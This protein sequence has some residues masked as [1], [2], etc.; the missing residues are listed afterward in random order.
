GNDYMYG[1]IGNDTYVVDS[2]SDV[3][4]EN[5]GEGTDLILATG[6][7]TLG[8]NIENLTLFGSAIGT[9]NSLDNVM[10]CSSSGS[11]L[12]GMAG[13]DTLI[14]L[15]GN[16]TIYGGNDNDS[17]NGGAGLDTLNGGSGA[18]TFVFEAASA[19][20]NIDVIQDFN[21]GQSDKLDISDLLIGYTPGT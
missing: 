3:V 10:T 2:A 19:F 5:S 4:T 6:S 1:G 7:Y 14:G 21:T 17:I 13:N 15:A 8:S 11:L 16:D 9:G 20:S 12:Y 18:D